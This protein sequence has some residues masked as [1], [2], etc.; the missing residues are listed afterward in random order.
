[1]ENYDLTYEGSRVQSILDTGDKLRDAGYIFRGEATPSTVPGTPTER[2]AYIGGPGTYTNFGSSTVVPSGS[3]GVFKYTGSAWSNQVIACT[4]PISTTVQN[5]DTTVPTGK[6]VKTAVDAV[7]GA[8][9]DETTARADADAALQNAINAINNNIGN[10]YVYAG[11]AT[12]STSPVTGKVFYLAVQAG[13]YT[14]FGN[15]V[16]TAGLNV[17]KKNGSAWSV[18]QVIAIDAEPTQGSDHL[19]KSGGVLNSIIQNGPA[20]D[21]SAYN[22]QGGTLATYADLSAALTALNALPADFKKG[23]MSMKYVQTS[24][25]K[26][27]QYICTADS[28]TTDVTKWLRVNDLAKIIDLKN[29][30]V[31]FAAIN[32]NLEAGESRRIISNQP[33][34]SKKTRGYLII[35]KITASSIVFND[36]SWHGLLTVTNPEEG[37]PIA[38][39]IPKNAP[40]IIVNIASPASSQIK[41]DLSV[42]YDSAENRLENLEEAAQTLQQSINTETQRAEGVESTLSERLEVNTHK[43]EDLS[44]P[45]AYIDDYYNIQSGESQRTFTVT[46]LAEQKHGYLRIKG[47]SELKKFIFHN[48]SWGSLAVYENIAENEIVDIVIPKNAPNIKIEVAEAVASTTRVDIEVYYDS[49]EARLKTIETALPNALT[50]TAQTLTANEAQQ[51]FNNIKMYDEIPSIQVSKGAWDTGNVTNLLFEFTDTFNEG[52]AKITASRTPTEIRFL[53]ASDN[54]LKTGDYTQYDVIP[55]GTKKIRLYWASSSGSAGNISLTVVQYGSAVTVNYLLKNVIPN[56]EENISPSVKRFYGLENYTELYNI[57]GKIAAGNYVTY[58]N[59]TKTTE[60]IIAQIRLTGFDGTVSFLNSSWKS[61]NSVDLEDGI[62]SDVIIPRNT[63]HIGVI[64]K[65]SVPVVSATSYNL[66]V[67]RGTL[68]DIFNDKEILYNTFDT[69]ASGEYRNTTLRIQKNS[70]PLRCTARLRGLNGTL[71]F[72]DSTWTNKPIVEYDMVDGEEKEI[73]IPSNVTVVVLYTENKTPVEST[74]YF[75]LTLTYKKSDKEIQSL[76]DE[77][78][79]YRKYKPVLDSMRLTA[80]NSNTGTPHTDYKTLILASITDIHDEASATNAILGM[81]NKFGLLIDDVIGL[82]DYQNGGLEKP[83]HINS[84]DGWSKVLKTIGNHDAYTD[85]DQYGDEEI[86]TEEVCYNTFMKDDIANW[87]VEYT[88]NKCYFYKDY[89][90]AKIR[91]VFVDYMHYDSTQETWLRNI[92]Y[93]NNDS[94]Y[95]KGYHVV[96]CVHSWPKSNLSGDLVLFDNC[97]FETY[98]IEIGNDNNISLPDII[99]EFQTRGGEFICYLCGHTH[100]CFTGKLENYPRQTIIIQPC[101]A[102][103]KYWRDS[104]FTW[105]TDYIA[106]Y[107]I[108]SFDTKK[109]FIRVYKAGANYN[110]NLQHQESMLIQYGA[111]VK[112]LSCY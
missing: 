68:K 53:D 66:F 50:K 44:N 93:N 61:I 36:S 105:D 12:P 89:D 3:I 64:T 80:I 62:W 63:E 96:V 73:I 1:M 95:E 98:D 42:Y 107:Y 57:N 54:T 102:A 88:A 28:F 51:V 16:V 85:W 18:D 29:P 59:V 103:F 21:L 19:V 55:Q 81:T 71:S 65:N 33:T 97:S 91:V 27:V 45:V 2:V 109:K 7:S 14:N 25:N 94:A 24:D 35:N 86:A 111:T 43:I 6:A 69:I 76:V 84:I 92:L 70:Y 5:N 13:T 39:E 79:S 106:Q 15:A 58:N 104:A 31:L 37:K 22:A 46:P 32:Y 108:Y 41:F 40:N 60:D 26:Y 20:F 72:Q 67:V 49:A 110:R 77:V 48:S 4:V 10:G 9:S 75:T 87:G 38:I 74:I 23:G 90:D 30:E 11:V 83:L 52:I 101:S 78:N 17:L 82:G 47:V 56:I 99:D 100:R 8:V 34:V 112:L